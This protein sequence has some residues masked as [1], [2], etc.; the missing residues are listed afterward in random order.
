MKVSE[1]G[2]DERIVEVLASQGI[3]ELY[4]PQ[5]EALK[6][7]LEGKSTVIAVP[8][9]SGKSLIAYIAV[10]QA[11]LEGKKSL[12]VVPLRALASEKYEDLKQFESLGMKVAKTVGDF[13]AP[14]QELKNKD[15]I[16]ATSERADSLLRHKS[17]WMHDI[18]VVI[19]DE[20]HLINDPNRGPT[21]EVTLVRLKELR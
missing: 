3:E 21:L 15:I 11:F 10:L 20:I 13:D 7:V 6:P 18:G 5:E 12:Y 19:S 14:E 4:P 8:T 2:I 9:A 1:L 17:D 16:V